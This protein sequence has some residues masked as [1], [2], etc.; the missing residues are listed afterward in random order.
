MFKVIKK[1]GKARLGVLK[2]VILIFTLIYML[3]Y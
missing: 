2:S 1:E 3:S